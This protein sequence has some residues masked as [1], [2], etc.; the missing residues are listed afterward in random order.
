MTRTILRDY[1]ADD[2]GLAVRPGDV[3]IEGNRTA[4]FAPPAEHPLVQRQQ[5]GDAA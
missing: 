4:P 5:D 1:W 3:S 2:G